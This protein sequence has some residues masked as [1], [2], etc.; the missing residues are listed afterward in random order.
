VLADSA[1][2]FGRIDVLANNAGYSILGVV[3]DIRSVFISIFNL[4][5][6]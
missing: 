2:I 5:K 3:E 1:K 4:L 6:I